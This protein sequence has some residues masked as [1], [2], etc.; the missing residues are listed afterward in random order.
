MAEKKTTL[1]LVRHGE[2]S[3]NRDG[4]FQGQAG[5]SLDDVGRAQ[6]DRVAARLAA[7]PIAAVYTSDLLRARQTAEAI[8]GRVG[9]VPLDDADLREVF[10]GAWQGL[11][12][13]EIAE[14]FPDE[15]VAWKA[16]A[17]D[18]RRG[19]GETYGELALRMDRALGRIGAAHLGETVV[20]VSHGAALKTF[21]G[22]VLGMGPGSGIWL[23]S[24]HVMGNTA[25]S[26]VERSEG[27][28]FQIVVWNDSAHLGDAAL[29][30]P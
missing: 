18:L 25:V 4:I 12:H 6:A 20:V 8:G 1:I 5:A 16:G 15:W 17:G 11:T 26:V 30:A 21:A 29:G 10:L 13:G 22:H 28:A 14:R 19:G 23:R 7:V 9:R 24:F 27:G 2:T 3:D